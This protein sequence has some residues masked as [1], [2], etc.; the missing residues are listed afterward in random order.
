M[1]CCR[2][3]VEPLS[4][5]RDMRNIMQAERYKCSPSHPMRKRMDAITKHRIKRENF[6]H[7]NNNLKKSYNNSSIKTVQCT[8]SSPPMSSEHT[9]RSLSISTTMPTVTRDQEDTSK[10]LL[11]LSHIDG[12]Y[13]KDTW[14][15][16]YTDGSAADAVQDSSAGSLIYRPNGQTLEATS[17]TGKYCT[18]YNA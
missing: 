7:K 5:R 1:G 13:P 17:A 2:N 16:V 12:F 14:I 9:R 3:S 15:H 6:I 8:Y 18:N 10:K 11:T 4:K